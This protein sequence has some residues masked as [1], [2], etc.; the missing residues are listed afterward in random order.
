[1]RGMAPCEDY[2]RKPP[3]RGR[4]TERCPRGDCSPHQDTGLLSFSPSS[5]GQLP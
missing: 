2:R 4:T 5:S 3:L 1:M